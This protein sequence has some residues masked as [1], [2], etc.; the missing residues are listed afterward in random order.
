MPATQQA[1]LKMQ[2]MEVLFRLQQM[3]TQRQCWALHALKA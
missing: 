3:A 2:F 1:F